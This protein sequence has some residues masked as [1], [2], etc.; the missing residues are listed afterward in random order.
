MLSNYISIYHRYK[1]YIL[2]VGNIKS[3]IQVFIDNKIK[4]NKDIINIKYSKQSPNLEGDIPD[5]Y[6][7][8]ITYTRYID[9]L[10][11]LLNGIKGFIESKSV[12]GMFDIKV[13]PET[14]IF[15]TIK[16]NVESTKISYYGNSIYINVFNSEVN[17]NVFYNYNPSDIYDCNVR[18]LMK[19][20]RGDKLISLKR[21]EKQSAVVATSASGSASTSTIAT[22]INK[23]IKSY[24]NAIENIKQFKNIESCDIKWGKHILS[25]FNEKPMETYLIPSYSLEYD[26]PNEMI[27]IKYDI[28]YT[29][30]N[31][32]DDDINIREYVSYLEDTRHYYNNNIIKH[33]AKLISTNSALIT[34]EINNYYNHL[35]GN[36]T[37]TQCTES[38][39]NKLDV[40]KETSK[41]NFKIVIQNYTSALNKLFKPILDRHNLYVF[42][43]KLSHIVKHE[44]DAEADAKAEAESEYVPIVT[45]QGEKSQ[46][47]EVTG[48]GSGGMSYQTMDN[49]KINDE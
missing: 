26:S 12:N 49:A 44:A 23:F 30:F 17:D 40:S 35:I 46:E 16:T 25:F 3:T 39:Y 34:R 13:P 36:N 41:E 1:N 8:N 11:Q 27:E 19:I 37:Y 32:Y 5:K 14:E 43:K 6:K 45:D 10:L 22:D 15:E 42:H 4:H 21:R 31:I 29:P 7:C 24:S 48:E 9:M 28:N 2:R 47:D 20:D 33:M 18:N 38:N